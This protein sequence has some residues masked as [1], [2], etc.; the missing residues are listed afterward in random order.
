MKITQDKVTRIPLPDGKSEHIVFDQTMPG[1]GVRIR[2]GDKGQHRTFIAQYKIGSKHRRIT[3]G[4][5]AKVT[6]ENARQEA[7]RIFGKVANGHDPANE[8]AER[9]TAASHTLDATIARYLETKAIELKP[10]SLLEVKRHLEKNWQPLHNISIASISRANVAATLSTI[11][12]TNGSV[13]ANRARTALS[14]MFRWAIGEGRCDHNAVTG[15]NIQQENGHRER[16]LSDSEVAKVWLAAPQNDYGTIVKLLMLTG[17]RREEIGGLK[18]S[19]V[20]LEAR[21]ITIAKERTKNSQEHVVPLCDAAISILQGIMRRGDRDFVFGIARDGGFS[22]W[23]KSKIRLDKAVALKEDW[24]LHDLRRT[25][26]TGLGK[27][28]VQPHVAEAVLNHLPPK[29]IRTYD[30]NTYAAEKKAA[31]DLWASHVMVA[32]VQ[33]TGANVTTIKSVKPRS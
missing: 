28:G 12:K 14:A 16:S 32:I 13:T 26:R 4:N 11:A 20:D 21:T 5:V 18:W 25:V 10:R 3:L 23:A 17:C 8:K 24:R 30:R 2:A 7:R 22:G 15:T 27:L 1:F 19:E 33:A 31:L 6:L 9:R 29:L